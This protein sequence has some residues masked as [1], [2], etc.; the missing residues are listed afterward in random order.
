MRQPPRNDR[1]HLMPA[2]SP[3]DGKTRRRREAPQERQR[4]E[5]G[6]TDQIRLQLRMSKETFSEAIGFHPSTYAGYLAKGY[7]TQTGAMA[8]ELL[9]RRE[10]D[11][12][13]RPA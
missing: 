13:N 6:P 5:I 2:P 12:G 3:D 1:I 10:Q 7:I 11:T 9:L 4:V 8:A